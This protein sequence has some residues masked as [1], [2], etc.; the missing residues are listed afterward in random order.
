MILSFIFHLLLINIPPISTAPFNNSVLTLPSADNVAA[1]GSPFHPIYHYPPTRLLVNRK[2][3]L[4]IFWTVPPNSSESQ[5]IKNS[6]RYL[7]RQLQDGAP[8][9]GMYWDQVTYRSVVLDLR[10]GGGAMEGVIERR[11]FQ[12]VLDRVIAWMLVRGYVWFGGRIDSEEGMEIGR[13]EFA[14]LPPVQKG[15]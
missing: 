10:P 11:D 13:V 5:G 15:G 3:A 8:D 2:I 1:A 7:R 12:A 6:L 9:D 4:S 14:V